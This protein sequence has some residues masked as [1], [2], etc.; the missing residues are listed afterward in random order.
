MNRETF[1]PM[2]NLLNTQ[3]PMVNCTHG[4]TSNNTLPCNECAI[5]AEN[6]RKEGE[7]ARYMKRKSLRQEESQK[8]KLLSTEIDDTQVLKDFFS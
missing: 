4:T 6:A 7:N 5:E 8:Q 1:I 2:L 3:K